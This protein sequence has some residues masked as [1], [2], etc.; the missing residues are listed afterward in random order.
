MFRDSAVVES[1]VT[2]YRICEIGIER[3]DCAESMTGGTEKVAAMRKTLRVCTTIR[4]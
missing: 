4:Y 2:S 3:E 1:K